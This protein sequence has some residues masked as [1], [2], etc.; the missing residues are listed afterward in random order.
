[1]LAA[2]GDFAGL[3]AVGAGR[4][5]ERLGWWA[6]EGL[7]RALFGHWPHLHFDHCVWLYHCFPDLGED[8]FA[9]GADQVVV[10]FV[11]VLADDVDVEEGL[12]DECFH[13]LISC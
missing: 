3:A 9:I 1:M 10:P 13:A 8:D 11:D 12:L 2:L 4:R 5:W 7:W 6:W